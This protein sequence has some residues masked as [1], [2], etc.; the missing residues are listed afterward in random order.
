MRP[1]GPARAHPAEKTSQFGPGPAPSSSGPGARAPPR[2]YCYFSDNSPP[3]KHPFG[4]LM[5]ARCQARPR[6]HCA[7]LSRARPH[8][9]R[10][11]RARRFR[12]A[13]SAR[14]RTSGPRRVGAHLLICAVARARARPAHAPAPRAC[15]S[16]PLCVCV[17]AR[18]PARQRPY[19]LRPSRQARKRSSFNQS[20]WCAQSNEI[21]IGAQSN[22]KCLG[23]NRPYKR[24]RAP[25]YSPLPVSVWPRARRFIEL[26]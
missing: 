19:L 6:P 5:R 12:P 20:N 9:W 3:T 25:T 10:P 13:S 16:G 15:S 14:A 1:S 7:P 17:C 8:N 24:T 26:H 21:P 11:G 23:S 4:A 22:V 18:N 2:R